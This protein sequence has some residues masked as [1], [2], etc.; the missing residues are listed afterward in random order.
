[1]IVAI[2]KEETIEQVGDLAVLFASTSFPAS[3][4]SEDWMA[5]NGVVPVTYFKPY[6]AQSEKLVSTDPYMEDGAVYAV[7]VQPLTEDDIAAKNVAT[8][9]TNKAARNQKLTATDWT[10]LTDV[11][12]TGDCKVEFAAYRQALRDIDPLNPVWPELPE[13]VWQ[14]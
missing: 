7:V 14:A 10:Q 6:D 3:G 9:A 12:L 2:V 4:P 13:E 5:D 8:I 1:M 11:P